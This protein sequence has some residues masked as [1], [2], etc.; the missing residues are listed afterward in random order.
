MTGLG[1]ELVGIKM[2]A[3]ESGAHTVDPLLVLER[4]DLLGLVPV[5]HEAIAEGEGGSGVRSTG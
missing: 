4:V 5:D 2:V 3:A 1:A